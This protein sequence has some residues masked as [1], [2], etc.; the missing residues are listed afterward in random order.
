MGM[1]SRLARVPKLDTS[2]T[3]PPQCTSAIGKRLPTI[4]HLLKCRFTCMIYN[5]MMLRMICK[6]A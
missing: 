2:K 3:V 5:L 4:W 6:T 1:V